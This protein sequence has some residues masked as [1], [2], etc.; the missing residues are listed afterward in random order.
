MSAVACYR[1]EMNELYKYGSTYLYMHK[2]LG[3]VSVQ[4]SAVS[5]L[6]ERK[7]PMNTKSVV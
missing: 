5:G 7:K 4:G 2:S 1:Q 3:Y 6:Q